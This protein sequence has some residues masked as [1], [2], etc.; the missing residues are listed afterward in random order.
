V[1]SN[2]HPLQSGTRVSIAPD[3][4]LH[5]CSASLGKKMDDWT[6]GIIKKSAPG[7]EIMDWWEKDLATLS[8]K[9]STTK[10]S[11]DDLRCVEHLESEKQGG[12]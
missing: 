5:F 12:F 9:S 8:K 10:S 11:S 1:Q 6:Q 7:L 3:L 2:L 4:A